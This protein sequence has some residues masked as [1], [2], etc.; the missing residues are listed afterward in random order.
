[1]SE[2]WNYIR[3]NKNAYICLGWYLI[4]QTFTKSCVFATTVLCLEMRY[5][6][7]T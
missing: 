7:N 4:F 5:S 6:K 2:I 1:M 3:N